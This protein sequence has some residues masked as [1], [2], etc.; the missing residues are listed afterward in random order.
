M[1]G[2]GDD[3]FVAVTALHLL[4]LLL[5]LHVL[6]GQALGETGT[7]AS[8]GH[9]GV[10]LLPRCL[11]KILER[12]EVKRN[13]RER[14]VLS[15][16]VSICYRNQFPWRG[17]L[18]LVSLVSPPPS[19]RSIISSRPHAAQG[20]AREGRNGRKKGAG[21]RKKRKLRLPA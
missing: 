3:F 9:A 16:F 20:E 12:M 11:M 4:L 14:P 19:R 8:G 2:A 1:S 18:S 10:D 15:T 6:Q 21:N 7:S 5:R 13:S 17:Y